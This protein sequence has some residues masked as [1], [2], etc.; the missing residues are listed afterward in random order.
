[1]HIYG[2]LD[3]RRVCRGSSCLA[4]FVGSQLC[5]LAGTIFTVAIYLGSALPSPCLCYRVRRLQ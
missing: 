3:T 5:L 4:V 2:L 1:M